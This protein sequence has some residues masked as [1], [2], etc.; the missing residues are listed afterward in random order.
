MGIHHGD[1]YRVLTVFFFRGNLI[2]NA[3]VRLVCDRIVRW[4]SRHVSVACFL[5]CLLLAFYSLST[6]VRKMDFL[7]S[8]LYG[9]GEYYGG[10]SE[11]KKRMGKKAAVG[12]AESSW[13][14]RYS[15][16]WGWK[17]HGMAMAALCVDVA[18]F[19]PA[20]IKTLADDKIEWSGVKYW[21]SGGLIRRVK[22]P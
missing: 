10:A 7:F 11:L 1:Y 5:L 6:F 16:C 3:S 21:K 20:A 9:P 12:D 14:E 17:Q 19:V 8:L 15:L 4:T 22:H 2:L 18:L 13:N